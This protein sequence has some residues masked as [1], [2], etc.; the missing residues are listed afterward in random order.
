MNDEEPIVVA[1]ARPEP[2]QPWRPRFG[3]GTL[4]LIMLICAVAAAGIRPLVQAFASDGNAASKPQGRA[5]FV[6]FMLVAPMILLVILSAVRGIIK[7]SSK[8]NRRR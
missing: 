1:E 8:L 5:Y 3:L 4:L 2:E 7:L 6:I